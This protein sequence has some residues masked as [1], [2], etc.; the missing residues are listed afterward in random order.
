MRKFVNFDDSK[1][2]IVFARYQKITPTPEEFSQ[3]QKDMEAFTISHSNFVMIVDLSELAFLPSE[4]RISQAKWSKQNDPVFIRQKM[5]IAFC[6]PSS[7]GQI[8]LKGVF[9]I[10]KPGIPY[11]VV[12]SVE[13][14]IEWGRKQLNEPVLG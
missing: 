8:M 14:A 13:Q 3:M 10:S 9:L 12:S 1:F 6:T 5:K 11:T 4:M 2:P 7:I